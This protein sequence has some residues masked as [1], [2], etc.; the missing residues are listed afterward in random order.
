MLCATSNITDSVLG[1]LGRFRGSDGGAAGCGFFF[2]LSSYYST[3]FWLSTYRHAAAPLLV[4]CTNL[5]LTSRKRILQQMRIRIRLRKCC[6][7]LFQHHC[8]RPCEFSQVLCTQTEGR[9]RPSSWVITGD[10]SL[11]VFFVCGCFDRHAI[12]GP[13]SF[14]NGKVTYAAGEKGVVLS[15]VVLCFSP[16]VDRY[17][18]A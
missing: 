15:G 10:L 5:R 3:H 9:A 16:L 14:D 18:T 17:R 6:A 4:E 2:F 13:A 7:F 1:K 11:R 12:S 8:I